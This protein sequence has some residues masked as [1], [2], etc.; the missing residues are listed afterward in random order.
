MS[1]V[2]VMPTYNERANIEKMAHDV[3]SRPCAPVLL[4]VDDSSPD[5][6]GEIVGK[7]AAELP[8]R[9]RLLSREGKSGL[10]RAYAAGFEYAVRELSPTAVVQMD[11]DGSHDPQDIDRLTAALD[12][13]DLVI[14]SRYMRGGGIEGWSLHRL[15][16]SRAGNVYA[17]ALL[18]CPIHDLTGGFKAWRADLLSKLDPASTASDGYAFQIE[19][20]MRARAAG[21]RVREVPIVFHERVAGSSKMSTKIA[22]EA[23]RGVP[24]MRRRYSR[25][26]SA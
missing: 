15:W 16:L 8:E 9:V 1:V 10:G 14:G 26:S 25:S 2:V 19:M 24:A 11:A 22:V 7:L 21:A 13:A 4:V 20:T 17:R 6:T 18:S 12:D 23:L 5:G 3:L